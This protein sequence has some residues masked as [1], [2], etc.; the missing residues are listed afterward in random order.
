[1]FENPGGKIKSI[2]KTVF[3]IEVIA[4]VIAAIAAWND[5]GEFLLFVVILAVGI[6]ISY[7]S[8]LG[9][10]AFGELV[11]NS[12]IIAYN[13]E[14]KSMPPRNIIQPQQPRNNPDSITTKT[15]QSTPINPKNT[16]KNAFWVCPTCHKENQMIC[17]TCGC[18]T[19]RP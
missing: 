13:V 5:M 4:V 9:L 7:L 17:G 14:R 10:F 12:T 8:A 15:Y 19:K 18:G 16:N 11:E 1:M 6:G 3:I 2:V